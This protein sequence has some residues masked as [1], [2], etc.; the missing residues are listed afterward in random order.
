[1]ISA[2]SEQDQLAAQ[3]RAPVTAEAGQRSPSRGESPWSKHMNADISITTHVTENEAAEW[4][5][6]VDSVPYSDV[7]QLSKWARVREAAGYAP[8]YLFMREGGRIIARA[9]LLR[10]KVPLPHAVHSAALR[11]IAHERRT[12]RTRLPPLGGGYRTDCHPAHR[13]L[14][15]PPGHPRRHEAQVAQVVT[16]LAQVRRHRPHRRQGGY[17]PARGSHCQVGRVPELPA[18]VA[19]I[20]RTPLPAE[21]A[22]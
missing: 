10:R 7:A 2:T 20:H 18:A 19:G 15:R 12:P 5:S 6:L 13:P 8:V 4:D 16:P 21:H 14:P 3:F 22:K 1:M 9:Q 17:P 11:R